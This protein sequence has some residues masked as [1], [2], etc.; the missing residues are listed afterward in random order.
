MI[1][2]IVMHDKRII[3]T[4][5]YK[6]EFIDVKTNAKISK[7]LENIILK[8]YGNERLRMKEKGFVKFKGSESKGAM[9]YIKYNNNYVS[10]TEKSSRKMKDMNKNS[11]L[12]IAFGLLS[13]NY[14]DIKVDII[15]DVKV[16]NEVYSYMKTKK[17]THYKNT[18]DN[19]VVLTYPNV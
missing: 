19:L 12:T 5:D 1:N 10:L 15:E 9:H 6:N 14:N 7:K 8:K 13:K 16:V 2:V 11:G 17:H 3:K 18:S 4:A